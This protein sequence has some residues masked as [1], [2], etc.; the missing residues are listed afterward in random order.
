M[1]SKGISNRRIL[2]KCAPAT[3][4]PS[5]SGVS[6]QR[7]VEEEE[8]LQRLLEQ[9]EWSVLTP[10]HEF[11]VEFLLTGSGVS[12]GWLAGQSHCVIRDG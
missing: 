12:V 2:K 6:W 5:M 10:S 7:R 3:P 4:S 9:R 11:A 1:R 8:V